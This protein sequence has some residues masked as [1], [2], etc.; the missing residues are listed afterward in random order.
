MLKS[1]GLFEIV[2]GENP[3]PIT[4]A[5]QWDTKDARAQ[6]IIAVRMEEK[7]LT[8][9]LSC[10][11]SSEVWEKLMSIY[12]QKSQVNVHLLQQNFFR[13]EFSNRNV[14]QFISKLE[15]IKSNLAQLGE[16]LDDKMVI[17]KILMSLPDNLRHFVSAW[18]S[19]DISQQT[20]KELTARRLIEEERSKHGE[21][22]MALSTIL[23]KGIKSRM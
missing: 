20:L 7:P 11:T 1:K 6:E 12:E 9:I 18:E 17:T 8:H 3:R 23:Q 10:R 14:A 19:T 16:E 15:E 22:V 4:E 13:L 2:T 21:E 5:T